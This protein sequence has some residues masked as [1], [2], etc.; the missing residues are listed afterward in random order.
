MRRRVEIQQ[1]V[2]G[3]DRPSSRPRI[4]RAPSAAAPL[5]RHIGRDR[6][7]TSVIEVAVAL[8]FLSVMMLG[9][10]DVASCYSAQM[11]IQQAAA[12][13]LERVQ[14]SGST[15]DFTYVR[16]EAAAAAGVPVTQVAVEDWLE[17]DNV[18]QA[19]SILVCPGT[20]TAS[21][22]VKVTITSAYT[23]YFAYSPLGTRQANG[24][25]SLS[26]SS[27]VRYS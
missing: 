27:S 19:A 17:C 10:I 15:V 16:T 14:T 11:S 21:R 9:L 2:T 24:S 26:A 1:P 4:A 18:K 25:K 5:L 6:R 12:R 23:P 20:Q 3:G 13:S 22:Y 8:P 7:G